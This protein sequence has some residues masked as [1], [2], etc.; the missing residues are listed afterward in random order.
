MGN[1]GSRRYAHPVPPQQPSQLSAH[2]AAVAHLEAEAAALEAEAAA[3]EAE[4]AAAEAEAAEAEAAA[5]VAEAGAES[6]ARGIRRSREP[7]C[8]PSAE[9]PGAKRALMHAEVMDLD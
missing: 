7:A 4:A 5:A 6:P 3:A 2:Q 1:W 8:S 9:S